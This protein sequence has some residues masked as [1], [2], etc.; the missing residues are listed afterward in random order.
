VVLSFLWNGPNVMLYPG[1][2]EPYPRDVHLPSA[3]GLQ[4]E[5]LTL[6]T[7]DRVKIRAYLLQPER[8]HQRKTSFDYSASICPFLDCQPTVIMF[9]GNCDNIGY[10]IPLAQRFSKRLRCNVLM[11]SPRGYGLSEGKP[12]TKGFQRDAD[13]ALNYVLSHPKLSRSPIILYGQSM[14]G[15]VAIDLA[16]RHADKISALI[17]ENTFTSLRRLIRDILPVFALAAP[18]F[19]QWNSSR[20]MENLPR[21]VALLMLSG[22]RDKVV[23]PAHM[24]QL[25]EA[26][27]MTTPSLRASKFKKWLRQKANFGQ[28]K[29]PREGRFVE[30][31]KGTH[32]DTWDNPAYWDAIEA[33]IENLPVDSLA[34]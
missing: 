4:Y 9:H 1:A 28:P 7:A 6:T 32:N 25:W 11:L 34:N 31:P 15:A 14:G 33:F 5:D 18:F 16:S 3:W 2:F 27:T 26:A 20:R 29:S 30:F 19:R 12:S 22:Q 24:R 23:P 13:A 17:V 21:S 8:A 10:T